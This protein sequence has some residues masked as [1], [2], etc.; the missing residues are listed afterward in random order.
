MVDVN[1]FDLMLQYSFLLNKKPY[2]L[3]AFIYL[4]Q[5]ELKNSV[6]RQIPP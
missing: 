1:V 4:L 5:L 3:H 6:T 2:L